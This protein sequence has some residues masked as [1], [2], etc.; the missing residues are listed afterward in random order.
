MTAC[1]EIRMIPYELIQR[2]RRSVTIT[3]KQDGRV[4]VLAPPQVELSAVERFVREKEEWIRRSV[5]RMKAQAAEK[6]YIYLSKE[7]VCGFREQARS[8][9]KNKVEAYARQMSVSVGSVRVNRAASRWGS[10]S[11]AG[12]LNF[13]YRL[14]FVPEELQD[15]VV[16]HELAHRREMNHSSRFWS[17]VEQTMP[18]YRER[19]AALRRWQREFEIIELE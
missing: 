11:A 10:C 16:V 7:Q 2:P 5:C 15:Y 14:L 9:L 18:D 3:V 13:S 6:K 1:E 4:V 8:L 12:N 17:V 19:R